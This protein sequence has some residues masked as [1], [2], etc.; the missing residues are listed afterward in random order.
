MANI[1]WNGST[2]QLTL[3]GNWV[4]GVAPGASDVAVFN[5]GNQSV[6]PS[7]GNIAALTG[8]EIQPGYGADGVAAIGGTGNKMTSS[9]ALVRHV[10]V[11]PFWFDDSAGTTVD[12]YIRAVDRNVVINLG[13]DTMT[14]VTL[15]RG[16][17][18]LDGS[19]GVIAR[20]KVGMVD[21]REQDVTLNVVTN[22]NAITAG[23]ISGGVIT[24]N[25][26][27]VTTDMS[28]GLIKL[29]V[30][31]SGDMG[32]IDM[33]GG[34]IRHNTLATIDLA[35]VENATL[36]LGMEAKIVTKLIELAGA[37]VIDNDIL[38]TI[39]ARHNLAEVD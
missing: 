3:A 15:M 36:D 12:V 14:N 18:T 7:L 16:D 33:S 5:R 4:G 6:D 25:K 35:V 28:G 23:K 32:T 34:V 38:H 11:A 2:G 10:G 27:M 8:I 1:V 17:I 26:E 13:G 31:T 24:L 21:N 30:G 19:T 9:V 20:L 39:T 37:N 29:P 22:A